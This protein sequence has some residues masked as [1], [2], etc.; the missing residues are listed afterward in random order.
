MRARDLA[1]RS[2]SLFRVETDAA[3]AR[4]LAARTRQ[5]ERAHRLGVAC[6][7]ARLTPVELERAAPL[8]PPTRAFLAHA[9][10]T[11]H[12]S[13]RA[14]HRTWRVARTLADL[15]GDERVG[16]AA[17]AEAFTLRQI[18]SAATRRDT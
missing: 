11:L 2:G 3:R 13:A 10:E 6:V 8:D 18:F 5:D 16:K 15:A 4:V 7:N 14:Y 1:S 12:Q 9:I 17:I